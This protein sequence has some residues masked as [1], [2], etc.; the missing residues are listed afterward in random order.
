MSDP[1]ILAPGL[2]RS[3]D[4]AVAAIKPARKGRL[5]AAVTLTGV[6]LS[7]GYKPTTRFEVGAYIGKPWAKGWNAGARVGFDF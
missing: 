4:A 7:A 3:I 6:E 1:V 5:G 2:S